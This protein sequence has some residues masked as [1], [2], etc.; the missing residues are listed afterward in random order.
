MKHN[1]YKCP[2]CGERHDIGSMKVS[3]EKMWYCHYCDTEYP[4]IMMRRLVVPTKDKDQLPV[5]DED[6]KSLRKALDASDSDLF[7]K[8]L[9]EKKVHRPDDLE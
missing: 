9:N 8:A 4:L 2:V 1:W 3:D 6:V 5:V 7:F